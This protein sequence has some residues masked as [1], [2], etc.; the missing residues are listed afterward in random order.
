MPKADEPFL[1]SLPGAQLDKFVI[2][3]AFAYSG[4]RRRIR[5]KIAGGQRNFRQEP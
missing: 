2:Y 1:R 3:L 5:R 4:A